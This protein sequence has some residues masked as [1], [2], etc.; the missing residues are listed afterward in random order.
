MKKIGIVGY[1]KMGKEIFQFYYPQ[2]KNTAFVVYCRH[3]NE[4]HEA[5]L[6]KALQKMLRR[7]RISEETFAFQQKN[8]Y[9]T[10]CWQEFSD[11]DMVI[12]SAVE[13]LDVKKSIFSQLEQIVSDKCLLLTNTSSLPI[14]R[15][16]RDMLHPERCF[17]LH[18]FYPLKLTGFAELNL[19]PENNSSDVKP[20]YDWVAAHGKQPLIFHEPYHMYLNQFLFTAISAG[21]YFHDE[22]GCSIDRLENAF[23][24]YFPI[25]G[26]FGLIDSIGLK[27]L[28]ESADSFYIKRLMELKKYGVS[29]M[30]NW[31]S[32]GVSEEPNTFLSS[33][34][35]R[36]KDLPDKEISFPTESIIALLMNEAIYAAEECEAEPQLLLEALQDT[37]GLAEP[38][39][40][41]FKL[42][43]AERLMALT[44]ELHEKAPLLFPEPNTLNHWKKYY[45]I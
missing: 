13:N 16:F 14:D 10:D 39:S 23:R 44:A 38:F 28:T 42:F 36:E 15:I 25:G 5:E 1:G 21:L 8:I 9:F 37:V 31:V 7:K 20:V 18:Y 30:T 35:E 40:E 6:N 27:L 3:D 26:L 12:E 29:V 45:D 11:C 43:G 22:S 24:K 2:C 32:S 4:L 33:I 17:G 34:R 41:Y 19:L